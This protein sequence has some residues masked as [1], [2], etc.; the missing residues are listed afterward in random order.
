[1]GQRRPEF[2]LFAVNRALRAD[3]TDLSAQRL[4]DR[5]LEAWPR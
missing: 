4:R 3:P 5:V 1:L 2:A